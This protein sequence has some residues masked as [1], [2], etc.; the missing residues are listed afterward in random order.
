MTSATPAADKWQPFRGAMPKES[1]PELVVPDVIPQDERIWVPVDDNVWFRPLCMSVSRGDWVNLLRVRRA[2]VL[3]RHRHPQPVH[4][5]VI[6]GEW[7]Y[8]EHDWIATAGSYV[9]EAPGE[10]HTLVVPDDCEEMLTFFLVHGA[11][12]Y[13]DPDGV[14][15]GYDDVFTRRATAAAHYER[16]GLGAGAAFGVAP[17]PSAAISAQV[18]ARWE[19]A[20]LSAEAGF[21]LPASGKDEGLRTSL[22]TGS[23]V[24]CAH[25]WIGALCGTFSLGARQVEQFRS[26]Q[27]RFRNG[28]NGRHPSRTCA[29]RRQGLRLWQRRRSRGGRGLPE[30][31]GRQHHAC[32]SAPSGARRTCAGPRSGSAIAS[33]SPNK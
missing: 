8:L 23:I 14:A 6:K 25:Y 20:S 19:F 5:Y 3:S 4:G 18:G 27:L 32:L 12:V 7:R 22:I 15:T 11:L 26:F 33:V 28:W 31:A 17:S 24:P 21:M 1:P 10:T 13:V 30:R 29:R 16:V 9:Y 2:G